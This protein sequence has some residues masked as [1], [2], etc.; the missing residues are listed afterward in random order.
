MIERYQRSRL[1]RVVSA[2]RA[3]DAANLQAANAVRRLLELQADAPPGA[4]RGR[5]RVM[6]EQAEKAR[7]L[8]GEAGRVPGLPT[9][10]KGDG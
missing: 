4:E 5:L 8:L 1:V 2:Q 3:L 9:I 6:A 10:P 7:Y